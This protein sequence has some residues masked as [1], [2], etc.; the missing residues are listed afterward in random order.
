VERFYAGGAKAPRGAWHY[1]RR[2]DGTGDEE[3]L[4]ASDRSQNAYSWSPNN[5][6]A[7]YTR[8]LTGGDRDIAVL[9]GDNNW[10]R[11]DILTTPAN[12]RSPAFSPGGTWLAYADDSSGADEIDVIRYP[13]LDEVHV[14][15]VGGGRA[16]AW[17]A[18][19]CELFYI[20][21]EHMMA[22]AIEFEPEFLPGPPTKLFSLSPYAR[23]TTSASG[24]REYDVSEDGRFLM[25]RL[26]DPDSS[27]S[28]YITVVLNWLEELK[29]LLPG[30]R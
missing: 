13:E 14:I 19:G 30:G 4:P 7:I 10:S 23:E 11:R 15:S 25:M 8:D 2:A 21:T 29:E 24:S 5:E 3:A 26:P 1:L 22:V 16:P 6:L 12:E 9:S 28:T 17:S 27:G 18:D 20:G